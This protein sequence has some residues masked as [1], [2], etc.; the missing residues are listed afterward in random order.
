MLGRV[1]LPVAAGSGIVVR[2]RNPPEE[3]GEPGSDT[4]R[5]T[6]V[7]DATTWGSSRGRV[8]KDPRTDV[9]TTEPGMVKVEY[10]PDTDVVMIELGNDVVSIEPAMA[11]TRDVSGVDMVCDGS[12]S[13]FV[14]FEGSGSTAAAE[15]A[16]KL[17]MLLL[18]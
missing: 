9:R 7:A 3:A 12:E 14:A 2:V 4:M 8:V 13:E 10:D 11:T 17:T 15:P 5:A 1:A 18:A 6:P 16:A